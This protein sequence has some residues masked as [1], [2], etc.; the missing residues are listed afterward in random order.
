MTDVSEKG[1][2]SI[3]RI[4]Q[5]KGGS[6]RTQS[7]YGLRGKENLLGPD[8]HGTI[9]VQSRPYIDFT[10]LNHVQNQHV[11]QN[12]NVQAGNKSSEMQNS[13]NIWKKY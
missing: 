2:V 6:S 12:W 5:P 9:L 10:L 4:R 11:G 13:S 3:L 1:S 7:S 8:G